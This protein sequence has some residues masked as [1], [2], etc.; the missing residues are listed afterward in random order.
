[1]RPRCARGAGHL[2]EEARTPEQA[3]DKGVRFMARLAEQL[4]AYGIPGLPVFTM[5]QG[6]SAR[7]LLEMVFG[8]KR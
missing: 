5:G 6:R 3:F 2:I 8:K 7:A 1:M 4:I